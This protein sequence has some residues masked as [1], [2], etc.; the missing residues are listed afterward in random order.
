MQPLRNL[1]IK[2]YENWNIMILRFNP[3]G[4]MVGE[5]KKINFIFILFAILKPSVG[6]SLVEL[7]S[8]EAILT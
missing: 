6:F 1:P 5:W 8:P 7:I 4:M 3:E 2:T